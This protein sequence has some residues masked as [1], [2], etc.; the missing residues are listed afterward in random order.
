VMAPVKYVCGFLKRVAFAYFA[1]SVFL[2]AGWLVS[3]YY[4]R[5]LCNF[6]IFRSKQ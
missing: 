6:L 3:R 5:A 4:V 2:E 1:W